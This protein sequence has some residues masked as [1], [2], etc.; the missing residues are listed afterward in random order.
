MKPLEG[1]LVVALEQAVAAPICTMRLADAGAR[2]V[3]IERP[4]GDLARHYDHAVKGTSA[5]FAWANRGKESAVLDVKQ[6]ADLALL[7]RM[8]ERA[9]VF[10]QNFAPGAAARLGL[11][12]NEL[13]ARHPKLIAVDIVGYGQD[14]PYRAMRAYDMLVQAESGICAVTGTPG[15]PSKVGVSIADTAA[16]MNAHAA[17]LEALIARARDGRGRA[18]EIALFD[19]MA[20]WMSVPLMHY[21]H[22]GHVTGRYGLQHASIY[23][24]APYRCRDGEVVIA[25]QNQGEWQRLCRGV[26]GRP[27]LSADPRFADNPARVANRDALEGEIAEVFARFTTKEMIAKLEAE[28]IAWAKVSG[29]QD[30]SAHPALRRIPVDVPGGRFQAVAPALHPHLDPGPVP[31][32]GQHTESIRREFAEAMPT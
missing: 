16:G 4:E 3:K 15:T 2:V 19:G 24:Y 12:S 18:I 29:L 27:Q 31:A 11:G 21:E 25:I 22:Q 10:I 6:P 23:P 5:Y 32:L 14:T 17:V 7:K 30:I 28:K 20:D 13:V 9:D 8:I 1:V 26:L